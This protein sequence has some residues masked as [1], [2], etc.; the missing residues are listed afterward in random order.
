MKK[1]EEIE[2][3]YNKYT[4]PT[5]FINTPEDL[6]MYITIG[7]EDNEENRKTLVKD[8]KNNH[9]FKL[10]D[11]ARCLLFF[12]NRQELN[13]YDEDN[14]L[15]EDSISITDR[16]KDYFERISSIITKENYLELLK[17]VDFSTTYY[18]D[19]IDYLEMKR[20]SLEYAYKGICYS[21]SRY[22]DNRE[23]FD[24]FMNKKIFELTSEKSVE[25]IK[26]V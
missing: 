11:Q 23:V 14:K 20:D 24:E 18:N 8:Y 15:I 10:I 6:F 16:Q 22:E 13:F 17:L 4:S 21:N 1:I 7:L 12:G 19:N 25:K 9:K 3:E 2:E 26:K 5:D